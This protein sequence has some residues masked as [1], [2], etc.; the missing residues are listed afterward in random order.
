MCAS[1][2][3]CIVTESTTLPVTVPVIAA[4]GAAGRAR[5][6][7]SATS[8]ELTAR[9]TSVEVTWGSLLKGSPRRGGLLRI[10]TD[11]RR[12]IRASGFGTS[13]RPRAETAP[14]QGVAR[15]VGRLEVG[16][17]RE[18]FQVGRLELRVELQRE[19]CNDQVRHFDPGV[20]AQVTPS[21]R[22]GR[23]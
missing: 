17:H 10:T 14:R 19:R 22:A 21:E 3:P 18:V 2:M 5:A 6:R 20:R 16:E 23:V 4:A 1:K 15:S 11:V 13:Q 8:V 12:S 7:I 9:R